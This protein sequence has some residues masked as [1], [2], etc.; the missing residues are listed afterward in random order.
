MIDWLN[1]QQD[2]KI[3]ADSYFLPGIYKEILDNWGRHNDFD[4]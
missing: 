1:C 3:K 2:F 4:K